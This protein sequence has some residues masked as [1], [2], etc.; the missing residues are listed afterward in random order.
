MRILSLVSAI[1]LILMGYSLP[2]LS[3]YPQDS[4]VDRM[5]FGDR[6]KVRVNAEEYRALQFREIA[7][8]VAVGTE[9]D[10]RS[11]LVGTN[12]IFVARPSVFSRMINFTTQKNYTVGYSPSG[13][14]DALQ[15]FVFLSFNGS[16]DHES[17]AW[18]GTA[19]R[20]TRIAESNIILGAM[21][22][23]DCHSTNHQFGN[24]LFVIAGTITEGPSIEP[25]APR[26]YMEQAFAVEVDQLYFVRHARLME[27]IELTT[28]DL[29]GFVADI[30]GGTVL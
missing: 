13:L 9:F 3:A 23:Y 11:P 29:A 10:R 18:S 24:C 27:S 14:T 2:S 16:A 19:A 22:E 28:G 30:A 4:V 17:G 15:G 25:G 12:V 5:V 21:D 26:L 6:P 8:H 20:M 7:N 1:I